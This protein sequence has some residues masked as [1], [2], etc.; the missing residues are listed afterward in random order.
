MEQKIDIFFSE[1]ISL[2]ILLLVSTLTIVLASQIYTYEK[3]L[4]LQDA[5]NYISLAENPRDYFTVP[6]QDALR[7]LP[8]I[9]I[10]FLKFSGISTDNC[11]KFLTFILFIYLHL[12]TFFLLKSFRIKNY[13]A[14]SAIAILFYSNHSVI[15]TVFNY[16]QLLDLLTYILIIYFIQ[17]NKIYD[18]KILF[19]VSLISIFTKEYL[20]ILVCSTYLKYFIN[21]KKRNTLLSLIFILIVF[22]FHYKFASSHNIESKENSNLIFLI[23]SYFSSLNLFI[24]SIIE[25]LIIEKN[26]F[27]FMPFSLLILSRSFIKIL[28]KNYAIILFAIVPLA[29]SILLF[30]NVGNNFFRVFY[31]G[32]FIMLLLSILFLNK[33]ILNDSTSK[34]LFFIS[35]AFLIIDYIHILQ[36]INQ[37]GFFNFFQDTRY[38]YFSGYYMFNL[39]IIFIILKHFKD[40]F[41]KNLKINH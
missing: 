16:Y 3:A 24:E 34:M 11:F 39:I 15:Y 18:L 13:L 6:H 29:F 32:Y 19:L 23:S 8:S 26:I 1:K 2:I 30:Q 28:I 21:Y 35:P 38:S 7:I 25:G 40:I 14:L 10:Y 27:L 9:I 5:V 12:K 31:H 33:I 37:D 20:L 36:S 22:T 17:L 41:F 4:L